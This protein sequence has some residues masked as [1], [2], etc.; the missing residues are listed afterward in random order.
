M[1]TPN[2]PTRAEIEEAEANPP[3]PGD[4]C[5][6]AAEWIRNR[7]DP[8]RVKPVPPDPNYRH[9]R[10]YRLSEMPRQCQAVATAR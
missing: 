6:E 9:P 8:S 1:N 3:P 5:E 2:Q 10:S 4:G 7:I